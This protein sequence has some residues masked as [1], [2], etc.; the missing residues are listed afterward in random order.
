MRVQPR[1]PIPPAASPHILPAWMVTAA[2]VTLV[3]STF[4]LAYHLLCAIKNY[5]AP[6]HKTLRSTPR[7]P[8]KTVEKD[9]DPHPATPMN[10]QQALAQQKSKTTYA[11]PRTFTKTRVSQLIAQA[12]PPRTPPP[13][14][15]PASPN[16][17][18]KVSYASP[19]SRTLTPVSQMNYYLEQFAQMLKH[20]PRIKD[21][22]IIL[23]EDNETYELTEQLLERFEKFFPNIPVDDKDQMPYIICDLL[24]R[25][26]PIYSRRHPDDVKRIQTVLAH[27]Q[28]AKGNYFRLKDRF[29]V[30][31]PITF[32]ML[33]NIETFLDEFLQP[34]AD[35]LYWMKTY[36]QI[37]DDP[38]FWCYQLEKKLPSMPQKEIVGTVLEKYARVRIQIFG[39]P[40]LA[41]FFYMDPFE[42]T[43]KSGVIQVDGELLLKIKT[44]L[45]DLSTK[46][47]AITQKFLQTNRETVESYFEICE[48]LLHNRELY[49]DRPPC[50]RSLLDDLINQ[51]GLL[52][53]RLRNTSTRIDEEVRTTTLERDQLSKQAAATSALV[54]HDNHPA[55][56]EI[57][58]K[59]K[60]DEFLRLQRVRND[61]LA[62]ITSNLRLTADYFYAFAQ[63]DDSA[64]ER[65]LMQQSTKGY[66]PYYEAFLLFNSHR[67]DTY[68]FSAGVVGLIPDLVKNYLL[69]C[70]K[71]QRLAREQKITRLPIDLLLG[72]LEKFKK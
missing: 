51:Y 58:T 16:T 9:A 47:S 27:Y 5:L 1:R 49:R 8:I 37:K 45:S 30:V 6:S 2:K 46:Q 14:S 28:Q 48:T 66:N 12:S 26:V 22:P 7:P 18:P 70:E 13:P 43:T 24:E 39:E 71:L 59:L 64:A 54:E 42:Y 25:N 56:V 40:E 67:D 19:P 41:P 34:P 50:D 11:S 4:V 55:L 3:V 23:S 21:K 62:L 68:M 57:R 53:I 33:E 65:W 72:G 29:Y 61:S 60:M 20:P 15:A 52:Q 38:L 31:F 10:A 44:V 35:L 36:Y 17:T 69:T 63:L 32:Q